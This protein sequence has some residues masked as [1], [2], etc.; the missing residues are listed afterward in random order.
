MTDEAWTPDQKARV[1]EAVTEAVRALAEDKAK[2]N[3]AADWSRDAPPGDEYPK[4]RFRTLQQFCAEY[5]P[6]AYVVADL[7]CSGSLYTLTARTGVG[8]TAWLISTALALVTGRAEIIGR[9]VE[10]GRVAFCTAENPD[11]VRMRFAVNCFHWNVDQP[12]IGDRLIISDNRVRP[13]EIGDYLRR[14]GGPFAAIFVE[15]WQAFFDGKEPNNPAEALDFTRRFRPLT[16]LP[17]SPTVV[18]AAHPVKRAGNDD[19]IPYGGGSTLNEVDGNLTLSTQ[20]SGMIELGWQGKFRGLGFEP[21]LYRIDTLHSPDIVDVKGKQIG[22]PVMLPTTQADA[23]A[24]EAAVANRDTRVLRA[25]AENPQGALAALARAAETPET[26]TNRALYKMLKAKPT[27]VR[28]TLG[29]WTLTKAGKEALG[30]PSGGRNSC[31][32]NKVEQ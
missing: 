10:Q 16:Q 20:A 30:G 7:L 3:G 32:T 12:A 29:K 25:L 19:L 1:V 15:T 11:G 24:R 9:A 27:L 13:E 21:P 2:P 17:G 8:K 22:L 4:P 18:L 6:I 14:D 23:E 5:R 26:T 28:K 31:S